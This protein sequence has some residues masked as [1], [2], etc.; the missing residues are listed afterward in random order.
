[1]QTDKNNKDCPATLGEYRRLCIALSPY[2]ENC[3]AVALLDRKIANSP[4]GADDLVIAPDSQMRI[5]LMPMLTREHCSQPT[6]TSASEVGS[7]PKCGYKGLTKKGGVLTQRL[8][9]FGD[10]RIKQCPTCDAWLFIGPSGTVEESN[11]G[12]CIGGMLRGEQALYSLDS[13][14]NR[15]DAHIEE[16]STNRDVVRRE[17]ERRGIA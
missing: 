9:E 15:V 11:A 4:I 6:E 10:G 7:C 3:E 1:M 13:G 17:I 2:R 16:L 5:L 12:V 8:G 14:L